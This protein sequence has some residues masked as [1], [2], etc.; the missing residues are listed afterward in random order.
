MTSRED[1]IYEFLLN[2]IVIPDIG[3]STTFGKDLNK[4]CIKMLGTKFAGVFNSDNIP[5]LSSDVPYTILNLDGNNMP[6]S[7]W[8]AVAMDR[9]GRPIVYDSF[10]RK[11]SQIIPSIYEKYGAGIRDTEY[12]AEQV[13]EELNCGAR[14]VAWLL[15]CD[16]WGEEMALKI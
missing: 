1:L 9:K 8:I 3:N 12:D 10:G 7:H 11:S 15:L 16:K 5:T 6:G 4:Y 2:A 13:K 14:C